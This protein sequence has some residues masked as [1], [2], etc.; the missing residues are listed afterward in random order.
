MTLAPPTVQTGVERQIFF[1]LKR[2]NQAIREYHLLEDGDRVAVAVSGGKDSLALLRLLLA[3]QIVQPER[4]DVMAVHLTV[5]GVPGSRERAEGLEAH[6]RAL[7]VRHTIEPLALSEGE[8]W[9]LPC[10][11]CA[12]NRRKTLFTIVRRFGFN[13]V[14]LGHHAD[15]AAQTTLLNLFHQ[16]R[17]ESIRP[18]R[19]FFDGL[20]TII[21]PLIQINEKDIVRLGK[22]AGYPIG[23]LSCPHAATSERA[24][25]AAI[26]REVEKS[27]RHAKASM[28]QAVERCQTTCDSEGDH[29]DSDAVQKGAL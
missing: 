29:S 9:P 16:G 20:I 4:I 1:M 28:R 8:T 23:E 18:S 26:L 12:W 21:R 25:M 27:A 14:A 3:R 19:P 11:R 24:R 15:D 5:P 17:L 7:D 10:H 2:F 13:K 22:A 6:F